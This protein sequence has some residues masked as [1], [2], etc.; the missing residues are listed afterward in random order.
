MR[1][2]ELKKIYTKFLTMF[3]SSLSFCLYLYFLLMIK[4]GVD[5]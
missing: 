2:S 5:V 4:G 1:A 3:F